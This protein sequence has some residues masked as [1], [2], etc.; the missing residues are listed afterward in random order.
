M[1]SLNLQTIWRVLILL[2]VSTKVM[3]LEFYKP[4]SLSDKVIELLKCNYSE[5]YIEAVLWGKYKH[6]Y[7]IGQIK[8]AMDKA[9]TIL[10][11]K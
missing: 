8:E 4:V 10:N 5:A 9:K 3:C 7:N 1:H 2:M 6:S 11:V